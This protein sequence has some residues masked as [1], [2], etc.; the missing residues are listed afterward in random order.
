MAE[1]N[2]KLR[3]DVLVAQTKQINPSFLPNAPK[4]GLT[5]PPTTATVISEKRN[6]V[7]VDARF[8]T[9]EARN[10]GDWV[11]STGKTLTTIDI[12]HGHRDHSFGLTTL[13]RQRPRAKAILGLE[14]GRMNLTTLWNAAHVVF[15]A[16]RLT[17]AEG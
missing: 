3:L 17:K 1:T 6:A 14:G 11:A 4:G 9:D 13:L 15:A 5:W 10:L 7:L 12:T 16:E 8:T 2:N